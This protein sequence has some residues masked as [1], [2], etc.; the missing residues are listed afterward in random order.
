MKIYLIDFDIN[1]DDNEYMLGDFDDMSDKEII[2]LCE[3]DIY[4]NFHD[5]YNGW[6][7]FMNSWNSD[8]IYYP[9]NA[10]MRVIDED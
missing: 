6:K 3:K 8:N 2:E 10:Y 1:V 7:Q 9:N 5:V 4:G